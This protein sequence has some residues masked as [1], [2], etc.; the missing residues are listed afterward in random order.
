MVKISKITIVHVYV[1]M[2][3]AHVEV[4][5]QLAGFDSFHYEGPGDCTQ[6]PWLVAGKHGACSSTLWTLLAFFFHTIL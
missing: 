2:L 4:R 3:W 6:L 5:E 1:I